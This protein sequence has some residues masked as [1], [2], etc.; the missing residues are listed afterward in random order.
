MDRCVDLLLV[1][2]GLGPAGEVI[3]T[4]TTEMEKSRGKT[5]RQESET[6]VT[7]GGRGL[8]AI[9]YG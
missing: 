4:R 9:R 1:E 7:R 3:S 2:W 8:D 6:L 5:S